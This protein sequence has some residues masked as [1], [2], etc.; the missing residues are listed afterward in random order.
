[1]LLLKNDLK[2]QQHSQESICKRPRMLM[3]EPST[4]LIPTT[5]N[6]FVDRLNSSTMIT[7]WQ[8]PNLKTYEDSPGFS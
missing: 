5:S 6:T 2:H 3:I 7:N 1:M 4:S 8:T